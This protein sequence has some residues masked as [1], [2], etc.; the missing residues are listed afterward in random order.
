MSLLTPQPTPQAS[1][2]TQPVEDDISVELKALLYGSETA[3]SFLQ[4]KKTN[5]LI[6]GVEAFDDIREGLNGGDIV[7][8]YGESGLGLSQ[9]LTSIC[10]EC[11]LP[12]GYRKLR[13]KQPTSHDGTSG[14]GYFNVLYIDLDDKFCV[15]RF[16]SMLEWR[17][18]DAMYLYLMDQKKNGIIEFEEDTFQIDD[19]IIGSAF[20][21]MENYVDFIKSCLSRVKII[22]VTSAFQYWMTIEALIEHDRERRANFQENNAKQEDNYRIVMVDSLNAFSQE[23]TIFRKDWEKATEALTRYAT[24]SNVTV[25]AVKRES[26]YNRESRKKY[27][28][29]YFQQQEQF[30]YPFEQK[31]INEMVMIH[32]DFMPMFWTKRLNYRLLIDQFP[33]ATHNAKAMVLQ[34]VQQP[35]NKPFKLYRYWIRETGIT[36]SV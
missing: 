34:N 4:R 30:N 20:G 18:R 31:Y 12:F 6:T 22:R 10:T 33:N 8:I 24:E 21:G 16:T 5:P 35:A 13:F 23:N 17:I 1:N 25:I 29:N 3:L 28:K 9:L 27:H 14:P 11:V 2:F 32:R 15:S 36:Y 7:E 19:D 26:L